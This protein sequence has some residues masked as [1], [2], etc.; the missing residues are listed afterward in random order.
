[1]GLKLYYIFGQTPLDEE[2]LKGLRIKTIS[3]R[4]QLNEFEQ[5]NI[6][7]AL[8]WAR[9][10]K[11]SSSSILDAAFFRAIHQKMFGEVWEWAGEFRSTEKNIGVPPSQISTQLKQLI[12]DV[13]F[14]VEN[15]VYPQDEIAIR[16]KHRLVS[17]HCFSNGNG[18]HSRLMADILIDK[19]LGKTM[20]SW[21]AD[22]LYRDN[23]M[24]K[25][26][27]AAVKAADN[28][29]VNPLLIF[30]RS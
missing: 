20:F 4:E 17:I 11:W 25:K 26:Y 13:I 23:E 9:G 19:I 10:K 12:D 30:A 7:D 8:L 21:G 2:E 1:M 6:E 27:I 22:G 3:T 16:F 24:R 14:W 29:D 18:R 28:G 5:K 15:K